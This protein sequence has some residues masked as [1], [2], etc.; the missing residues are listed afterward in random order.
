MIDLTLPGPLVTRCLPN[1]PCLSFP[2]ELIAWDSRVRE[3]LEAQPD[4]HS[5]SVEALHWL[6]EDPL[7]IA[8]ISVIFLVLF[9]RCFRVPQIRSARKVGLETFL[10]VLG[11][12]LSDKTSV[13][14]KV[15]FGRLK[16]HVNFYNP[17]VLPALSFPSSHA[18]NTAFYCTWF[19]IASRRLEEKRLG[20]RNLFGTFLFLLLIFISYSRIALGEHY[21]LDVTAGSLLGASFAYLYSSL[22]SFV[23]SKKPW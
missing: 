20:S 5:W 4:D 14:L 17:N 1:S 22:V 7:G 10:L 16:P 23:R 6:V 13:L 11:G 9:V 19:F 21:P 2:Q 18:F 8:L 12:A 3:R 15:Y